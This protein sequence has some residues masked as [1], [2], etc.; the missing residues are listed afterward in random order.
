MVTYTLRVAD[1][2]K[3]TEDSVTLCF[4][5]PAIRKIK[6][7]AGQY[8]TLIFRINGK[9][10]VRPYSFSSSPL[11]DPLLEV[12]VK[13][14]LNGIVSNHIHDQVRVGDVIEV[15]EPM[16]DF[17]IKS[18]EICTS[19]YFWGVGSGITPL[20]SLIKEV[21]V[22]MP[23]INVNLVYGNRNFESTI[24]S[25]Q[26]EIL[27]NSYPE[28]FKVWHF[29]TQLSLRSENPY[30]VEGRID[31]DYALDIMKGVDAI[32][33]T[34]YICGPAGLKESVKAALAEL[35]VLQDNIF[36]ED[37]ELIKDP[38]DFAEI[39]TQTIKL[40]YQ[41][42]EHALEIIKGKSILEAGLDAG[43]ELPYSCQTGNCS[44]C[45]AVC[46]RG[47]IKMIGLPKP[48]IDLQ[49]DEYLLC[50]SHPLTDNVYVTIY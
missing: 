14:V 24:F 10:Y 44:T 49:P 11:I 15:M 5:Q 7:R 39:N 34:H 20:I 32:N 43:L 35:S 17:I 37:F 25:N 40:Q 8:L 46:S 42:T 4:K 21:L 29:H 41:N 48:R 38:N 18:N 26:L 12:T 28:R 27:L 23:F 50:C 1:I 33:T 9:R 19:V 3:E 47:L 6:Y 22:S 31:K 36:D 45:K 16:G 30:I 2:R 13:R